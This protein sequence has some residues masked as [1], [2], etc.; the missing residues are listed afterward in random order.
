MIWVDN[1]ERTFVL[2]INFISLHLFFIFLFVSYGMALRTLVA[3]L[4]LSIM[5]VR[6]AMENYECTLLCSCKAWDFCI[7]FY[8]QLIVCTFHFIIHQNVNTFL[9]F[10]QV[11]LKVISLEAIDTSWHLKQLVL[12]SVMTCFPLLFSKSS[13]SAR[14]DPEIDEGNLITCYTN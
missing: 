7:I 9:S 1:W 12:H 3:K 10:N 4:E 14:H 5:Y 2:L 13:S 11:T 6:P 8:H